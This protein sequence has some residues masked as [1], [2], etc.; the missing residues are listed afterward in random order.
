MNNLQP[1]SQWISD[2]FAYV[3]KNWLMLLKAYIWGTLVYMGISLLII[4]GSG[5][6]ILIGSLLGLTLNLGTG[7]LAGL[8]GIAGLVFML[9]VAG[10]MFYFQMLAVQN[11]I[12]HIREEWAKLSYKDGLKLY[13]V[14]LL[15]V[16]A[17]YAGLLFFLIPGIMIFT[18]I[19]LSMF[20]YID[21]KLPGIRNLMLSR[22][23]VKGYFWPVL[24]R[25]TLITLISFVVGGLTAY[26]NM[27][28]AE[29]GG[30]VAILGFVGYMIIFA[31]MSAV[32]YRMV[33]SLYRDLVRVKGELAF[34]T[35]PGRTFR[36]SLLAYSPIVISLIATGFLIALN[37]MEQ[38]EKAKKVKESAPTQLDVI[39]K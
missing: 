33:Y 24:G 12:L 32:M 1:I 39:Q 30:V 20:V 35:T 18:W 6:L 21:R 26:L 17:G 15:C 11:P 14:L 2:S 27:Q 34:Q 10:K 31:V 13:W 38:I 29:A 16:F 25:Y 28:M 5:I 8:A 19:S 22:D 3:T 23:Y 37:P 36:W 9:A 4:F 7:I